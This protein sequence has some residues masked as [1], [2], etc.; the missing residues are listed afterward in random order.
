MF[1]FLNDGLENKLNNNN[2]T[3][4]AECG[5]KCCKG[6]P[7]CAF[8]EDFKEP[9]KDNLIKALS[10]GKWAIDWWE[11]SPFEDDNWNY[12][13]TAYYIRPATKGKEYQLKDPS[14]GGECT[15]LQ[16][17]GCQLPADQRPKNCRLLEPI[18]IGECKLHDNGDKKSAAIAWWPY[19]EL[20]ED[21]INELSN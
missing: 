14:W 16:E 6:M 15:F 19:N 9:L 21:I 12:A 10:T 13:Y 5:G 18:S 1:N 11:G 17:N 3:L 8:P 20:I 2:P 7:G 4:C